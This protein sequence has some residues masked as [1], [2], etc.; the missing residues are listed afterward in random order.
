ML[1]GTF[2]ELIDNVSKEEENTVFEKRSAGNETASERSKRQAEIPADPEQDNTKLEDKVLTKYC[3]ILFH[4]A[5]VCESKVEVTTPF[6]ASNSNGK[7]RAIVN[8][9]QFEQAIHQEICTYVWLPL[10][11][12]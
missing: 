2:E 3:P 12:H 6:W 11:L 9:E 8:N 1:E 5:D 10:G 4:R 7:V